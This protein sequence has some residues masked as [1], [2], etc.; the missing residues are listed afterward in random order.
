MASQ[1]PSAR[2]RISPGSGGFQDVRVRRLSLVEDVLR[3]SGS[4][5]RTL[6]IAVPWIWLLLFFLDPVHHRS[7]DQLRGY[8]PRRAAVHALCRMGREQLSAVE[9]QHREL[10]FHPRG[11]AVFQGV[12]ELAEGRGDLD[13]V[14]PAHRL[15]RWRTALR[16]RTRAGAT[17]CCC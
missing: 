12:S 7:Q 3:G 11:V 8:A 17:R 4:P 10:P 1:L 16:A 9:A 6:V 13:A 5:G 15:S 14:L 2:Q